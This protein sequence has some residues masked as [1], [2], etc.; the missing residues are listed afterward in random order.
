[1]THF[2]VRWEK[3]GSHIRVRLFAAPAEIQTHA[4]I[5]DLVFLEEEWE[6]FRRCFNDHG[7]DRVMIV[8]EDGLS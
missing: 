2:R 8:P 3:R 6:S 7:K 1:M 5:G 4:R